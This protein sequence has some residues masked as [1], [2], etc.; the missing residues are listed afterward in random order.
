VTVIVKS[1]DSTHAFTLAEVYVYINAL[2]SANINHVGLLRVGLQGLARPNCK[3]WS[4]PTRHTHSAPRSQEWPPVARPRYQEA[5]NGFEDS[6]RQ[7]RLSVLLC[8]DTRRRKGGGEEEGEGEESRGKRRQRPGPGCVSVS[9]ST[10]WC[11]N[12]QQRARARALVA[13]RSLF[14]AQAWVM[15]MFPLPQAAVAALGERSE[16]HQALREGEGGGDGE[17]ASEGA[18]ALRPL[19]CAR[20][21]TYTLG[22]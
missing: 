5:H 10:A 14:G 20:E 12:S 18:V 3:V 15:P 22:I 13:R 11:S 16:S 1:C 7:R 19:L 17:G 2:A 21:Q 6:C 8:F 9:R 4:D